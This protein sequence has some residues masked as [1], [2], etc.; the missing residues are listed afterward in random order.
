[1]MLH[2]KDTRIAKNTKSCQAF[3]GFLQIL[4]GHF[5]YQKTHGI[6]AT[7]IKIPLFPCK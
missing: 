6:R 3:T 2:N 5:G 7:N 4:P 1:M